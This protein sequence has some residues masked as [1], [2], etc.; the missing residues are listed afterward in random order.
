MGAN[1]THFDGDGHAGHDHSHGGHHYNSSEPVA[2]VGNMTAAAVK[3][4]TAAVG[5][6]TAPVK[7]ATSGAT[8]STIG[9]ATAAVLLAVVIPLGAPQQR[10]SLEPC[11]WMHD[12][13]CCCA[14][15]L[16]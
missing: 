16:C 8:H 10:R 12:L 9:A 4:T 2:Y 11:L 1:A 3:N 14:I 6:V 5:N 13:F 15:E 7:R